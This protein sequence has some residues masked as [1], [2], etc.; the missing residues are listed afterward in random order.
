MNDLSSWHHILQA[1]EPN[2]Y[3]SSHL[4]DEI[5][6]S[7]TVVPHLVLRGDFVL[8]LMMVL[9]IEVFGCRSGA[10]RLSLSLSSLFWTYCLFCFVLFA[11]VNVVAVYI[12]YLIYYSPVSV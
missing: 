10:H 12:I 8:N 2:S 5:R 3:Q 1:G 6:P 11:V 7:I 9:L 4:Q